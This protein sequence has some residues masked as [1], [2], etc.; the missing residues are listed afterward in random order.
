[1]G[2]FGPEP[3]PGD[4]QIVD[5]PDEACFVC[6]VRLKTGDAGVVVPH[7]GRAEKTFVVAHLSCWKLLIRSET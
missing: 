1:M 6:S 4:L 3:A 5:Q 7:L 2:Y